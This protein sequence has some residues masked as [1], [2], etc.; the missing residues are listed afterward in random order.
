MLHG[1]VAL[2]SPLCSMFSIVIYVECMLFVGPCSMLWW[3]LLYAMVCTRA[4]A[5]L[6]CG[7]VAAAARYLQPDPS[8]QPTITYITQSTDRKHN[9]VRSFVRSFER[10][11]EVHRL[12]GVTRTQ[13]T[14][15]VR[16][17]T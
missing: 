15:L 4:L 9:F 17:H 10:G 11:V 1:R 16:I 12:I 8:P 13:H 3:S 6:D 5:G 7:R 2:C 14:L